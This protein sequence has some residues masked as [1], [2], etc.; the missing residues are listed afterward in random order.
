MLF[1]RV[2]HAIRQSGRFASKDGMK[3]EI[4]VC[5]NQRGLRLVWFRRPPLMSLGPSV[6]RSTPM[7]SATVG[8]TRR[9]LQ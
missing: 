7:T 5:K 2:I 4:A 3:L 8:G 1:G 6:A 9:E